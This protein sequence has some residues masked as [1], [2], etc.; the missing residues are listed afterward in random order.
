MKKLLVWSLKNN[1]PKSIF[2]SQKISKKL[3]T[4]PRKKH[5][6][7]LKKIRTSISNF[8][9]AD[10][11][12][13]KYSIVQYISNKYMTYF[14]TTQ[15]PISTFPY[16]YRTHFQ[17][18]LQILNSDTNCCLNSIFHNFISP[19]STFSYKYITQLRHI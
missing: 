18:H 9:I 2:E 3:T 4:V 11:S 1:I 19:P 17:T 13:T 15:I 14:Q 10:L 16:E 5:D 7:S 6:S 12:L 8:R